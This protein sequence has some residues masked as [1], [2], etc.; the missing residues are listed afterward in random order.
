MRRIIMMVT[1]ALVMA[2]MMALSG[3]AFAQAGCQASGKAAAAEAKEFRPIG[4]N[5]LIGFGLVPVPQAEEGSSLLD[6][7]AAE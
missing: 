4:T 5:V 2:L 3:P 7:I 1:V 6:F